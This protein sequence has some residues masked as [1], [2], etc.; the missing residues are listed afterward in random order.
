MARKFRFRHPEPAEILR[1]RVRS[2]FADEQEAQGRIALDAFDQ[3]APRS[4]NRVSSGL[5]ERLVRSRALATYR[6]YGRYVA[7]LLRL[8]SR[9][10]AEVAAEIDLTE[11]VLLDDLRT[12]GQA[13][14]FV[15]LH[16]GNNELGAAGLAERRYD[17]NVVADDSAF[18]E[19]YALL[20]RLRTRW[21][22]AVIDWRA[23]REVF[24]VIK[25]PG[26]I[27]VLLSDW[28]WKPD[29]VPCKLFGRW[30]TLPSGP[31]ALAARSTRLVIW[32]S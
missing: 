3:R 8:P 16:A 10:A 23:I 24:T 4:L 31:A 15:G 2:V 13:A 1:H 32:S 30:T 25:R 19:M 21:G 17:V 18:P 14:V 28:G 11:T 6:S 22:I 27:L 7:E 29:G 26:G 12:R 9:A 20:R 5:A